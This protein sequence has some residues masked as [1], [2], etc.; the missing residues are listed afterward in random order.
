MRKNYLF[1]AIALLAFVT[2]GLSQAPCATD[3]MH[4]I[5]KEQYPEISKY[6]KQLNEGIASFIAAQASHGKFAAK[7]TATHADTD[8]YDI[9]VVIHI[10]HNY[11]TEFNYDTAVY[12]LIDQMNQFYNA[13]N[14]LST[15]IQPFKKY[16]GNAKFRFHLATIDP[17]GNPNTGITRRASY[18]TYGGDDQAKVDLWPPHN[19]YNIWFE[20]VI[21]RSIGAGIVLAYASF[22]AAGESNPYYDGVISRSDRMNDGNTI[23]HESGHYFDLAHPWN[24]GAGVGEVCGDDEVDDTPPTKGH[25][26]LCGSPQM[27]DTAC[28]TNNYK[29]YVSASGMAD[30]LVNY[31]DTTN[32]QN[33]MDYSDCPENMLTK[34]QVWRMRA[35][36]NNTIGGRSNLW[37]STNLAATGALAPRPDLFPVTDFCSRQTISVAGVLS[38]FT[39]PGTNLYF[40]NKS[41]RDTITQVDWT[42]GN[43]AAKPNVTMTTKA[44]IAAPFDNNFTQPGWVA[45]KLSAKG[46]NT[47]TTTTDYNHSV[48]VADNTARGVGYIQEFNPE[49]DRDMWPMFNYYNNNFKWQLA[50][51][52]VYDNHCVMYTG[53]DTRA[54]TELLTNTP[55]GDYDDLFTAPFDISSFATGPAYLNFSYSSASRTGSAQDITDTLVIDYSVD[56]KQTWYNLTT[57]GKG[58]LINQ[59]TVSTS[60]VPTSVL[61]WSPAAISLPSAARTPYTVFRFRYK[62]GTYVKASASTVSTGNNFYMDRIQVTPWAADV[63]SVNMG[64]ID[65]KV[66]PN[67]THGDAYIVVKDVA[68]GSANITVSDI[69]GKTVYTA[70]EQL[71]G[72]SATILI[73]QHAIT[74]KGVYL[75]HVAT[76]NM[77]GTQKLVVY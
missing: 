38:Y 48:F 20:N 41:W 13:Q 71:K 53:F 62:P 35:A 14:N 19:Y 76:G 26:S 28:A 32:T 75:V 59:G 68:S 40:T 66:V 55:K 33:V 74:V 23:E 73:P 58:T 15:I 5:Y 43:G 34:G 72:N 18:L 11:G 63:N 47:G 69:T 25:F 50:D 16:I 9:P 31:P 45:I 10:V 42:F 60:Y 3:E 52:G 2:K 17:M 4:K 51:Y 49:G 7:T 67:P 57:L 12:K 1:L 6:E 21:G 61:D 39:F 22:P 37:D 27:Y 64:S 77:V 46:N 24:S 65:M 56:K 8:Y 29:L 36:L 54:G 30:S 70:T 44:T